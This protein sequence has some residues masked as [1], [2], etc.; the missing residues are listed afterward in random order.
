M[1]VADGDVQAGV[2]EVAPAGE[3]G[4]PSVQVV[5][6]AVPQVL[7]PQDPVARGPIEVDHRGQIHRDH[8]GQLVVG[9]LDG[10]VDAVVERVRSGRAERR[11]VGVEDHLVGL[12]ADGV[13]RDLPASLVR[14]AD[15]RGQVGRLPVDDRALA[16]VEMDLQSLDAEAV[17]HRPALVIGVPVAEELVAEVQG[18]VGVDAERQ[19]VVGG[20]AGR[21][22]RVAPG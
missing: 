6:A 12:G 7:R 18:E 9:H 16:I 22:R 8:P 10:V 1:S 11:L 13:D 2:H 4:G 14:P 19:G 17:A 5:G 15:G 3:P 20:Q 21:A